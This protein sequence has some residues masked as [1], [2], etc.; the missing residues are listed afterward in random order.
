MIGPYLGGTG[1]I[2]TRVGHAQLEAAK[3][4]AILTMTIDHYG[5]IVDPSLYDETN[6]IGR[7]TYPLFAWIIGT[8]LAIDPSLTP[9][10]LA[11]ML[12]W[13][14]ISQ[15][16]YAWVSGNWLSPN[17][18][19]TLI[20]AVCAYWALLIAKQGQPITGGLLLLLIL[21]L[22]T[23]VDYGPV[24]VCM[25]TIIAVLTSKNVVWGAWCIS[26]LGFLSNFIPVPPYMGPGAVWALLASAVA[27]GFLGSG[28]KLPRLPKQFFYAYYP[29]HLLAL[30]FMKSLLFLGK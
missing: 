11:N 25:V 26:P 29:A 10:Y 21:S 24:G 8:R 30:Y 7:L 13:A 15:I 28:F 16:V 19:I 5:K 1:N 17:I 18:F 23:F 4:L 9:R 6:A 12:P 14:V 20:L 27:G 22:A 3:W 2:R